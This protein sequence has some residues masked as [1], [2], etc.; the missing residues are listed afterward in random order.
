MAFR[1]KIIITILIIA[2]VLTTLWWLHALYER[3]TAIGPANGGQYIEAAVGQP[4][5]INP[6]L[7]PGSQ[8]SSDRLLAKLVFS[9]LYAYDSEG[10]LKTD[11]ANN[12]QKSD[13]GL[14][15]TISIKDNITFHDGESL[16]ADD[17]VFTYNIAKDPSYDSV[18]SGLQ[19]A[20]RDIEIEK[21]DNYT[22]IF[23]LTKQRGDFLHLLTLGI[24]PQ[25]VW[26]EITPVQFRLAEFN[27]KPIGAG[28]YEYASSNVS[29]QGQI[30]SYTLRSFENYH[31]GEPLITKFVMQIYPDQASAIDAFNGGTVSGVTAGS[32]DLISQL[33]ATQKSQVILRR[34]SYFG[35]FFNQTKNFALASAEV[36]EA[37]LHS[38]NRN[39]LV[40]E[41]FGTSAFPVRSALLEGMEGYAE[42]EQQPAYNLDEAIKILEEKKWTLGEDGVRFLGAGE[43]KQRLAFTISVSADRDQ[44]VQT[45]EIL[46]RQWEKIG[47]EVTID[48]RAQDD[49]DT[50]I[51]REREYESLITFHPMR[52]DQPNIF[53]LWHSKEKDHPGLN[54]SGLRDGPMDNALEA[55]QTES[56][57][58]RRK[59]IYENIQSRI[60]IQD[61]AAF[62]FATGFLFAYDSQ[63]N[64]INLQ[65]VNAP[66]DRFTDIHKWYIKQKRQL[67]KSGS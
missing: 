4:T 38:I 52:W 43:E 25:H 36:R 54:Y 8:A 40:D 39:E 30:T 13:D 60:K 64:G 37:L 12:A 24:I 41:V 50:N 23:K 65:N 7:A 46:A 47:A 58:E 56:D 42:S 10:Q 32:R 5:A 2:I 22:V 51:V 27:Q 1:D 48:K 11:I 14:Q 62:L 55:L 21:Q 28:P 18:V 67:K 31:H 63:L 61:P 26:K 6:L 34:P 3:F 57:T 33:V 15:Y 45:A 9:G 53:A 16:T 19:I 17:I 49:L 59:I 66:Q 35:I 29:P 44:I 20:W